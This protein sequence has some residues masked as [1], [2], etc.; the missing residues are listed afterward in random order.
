MQRFSVNQKVNFNAEIDENVDINLDLDEVLHA[1]YEDCG[2]D[3]IVEVLRAIDEDKLNLEVNNPTADTSIE[4]IT[5]NEGVSV[6]ISEIYR[7]API[8]LAE[9]IATIHPLLAA[10]VN[11]ADTMELLTLILQKISGQ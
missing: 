10:V 5:A 11:K 3:E 8:T 9:N 1:A 2:M 4:T 6:V 7:L